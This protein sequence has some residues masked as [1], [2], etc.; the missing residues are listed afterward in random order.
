[1]SDV[2]KKQ[3]HKP[4]NTPGTLPAGL[5]AAGQQRCVRQILRGGF[6]QA[7][8]KVS[9]PEDV[10]ELEADRVADQV[11]RM[12][13]VGAIEQ[14]A[15]LPI[16]RAGVDDDEKL[17][18]Q[19][20][21]EEEDEEEEEELLQA[22]RK[23]D[24]ESP[25]GSEEVNN[26]NA[27]AGQGRPIAENHRVFFET[28]LGVDLTP[29]R[30]HA[31]ARAE[32]LNASLNARA[33]TRGNDIFFGAQQYQPQSPAGR[34]LLAHELVH[35]LQQ[36]TG[37]TGKKNDFRLRSNRNKT[38]QRAVLI[39]TPQRRGNLFA[40]PRLPELIQRLNAIHPGVIRYEIRA[41]NTLRCEVLRPD[42]LTGFDISMRDW[43]TPNQPVIPLRFINQHPQVTVDWWGGEGLVD[44][45]DLLGATDISFQLNIL[46]ILE[47]RFSSP[48]YAEGT[49]PSGR[50]GPAHIQALFRERDHLREMLGDN[51]I[52]YIGERA[53]PDGRMV[54]LFRRTGEGGYDIQHII[55]N[56]GQRGH[57]VVVQ[58]DRRI[59]LEDFIRR[60]AVP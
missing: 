21:D 23:S 50:F 7:K 35:V 52:E 57:L 53:T 59:P 58:N 12:P 29:V 38:V 3:K 22:K 6:V 19:V 49:A 5:N 4:V 33:F 25:V 34:H 14:R 60:R 32:Q 47:E 40:G 43:L 26:I 1:M 15:L 16:Q 18:R 2:T 42:E 36:S 27:L 46:H 31:D 41:D 8:L 13:D 45:D 56:R 30:I 55:G 48:G 28:H 20:E 11:M 37:A 9:Q 17:H 10:T 54:F 51:D 39:E 24:S 44:I